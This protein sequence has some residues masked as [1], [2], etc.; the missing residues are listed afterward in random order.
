[1]DYKL[2]C[3]LMKVVGFIDDERSVIWK[4]VLVILYLVGIDLVDL[5][6]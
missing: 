5:N 1:M 2:N 4:I 3:E 6:E